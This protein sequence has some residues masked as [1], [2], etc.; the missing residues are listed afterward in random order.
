MTS[1]VAPLSLLAGTESFGQGTADWSLLG[2]SDEP[3]REF[4]A[5]VQFSL[6]FSGP[7]IVHVS[8]VGFDIDNREFA[9]L[10]VR[11]QYIDR[12]GFTVA[13]STSFGTQV[14]GVDISWLAL[15]T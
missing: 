7:P 5:R 10:R 4:F 3:E 12:F 2:T 11:A 1:S 6:E 14:Y 15:G 13:I 9:R 8:V